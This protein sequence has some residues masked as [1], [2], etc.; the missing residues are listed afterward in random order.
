MQENE[1]LKKKNKKAG[2]PQKKKFFDGEPTPVP[3]PQTA[4][5]K[6]VAPGPT[7]QKKNRK[8][9]KE[10]GVRRFHAEASEGLDDK[11]VAE[12]MAQGLYN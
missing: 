1:T 10:D 5:P 2:E 12:R 8:T 7:P 9:G 11:Q 3:P 6:A 4:R